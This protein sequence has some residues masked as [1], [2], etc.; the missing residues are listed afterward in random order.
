MTT[1]DELAARVKALESEVQDLK[2]RSRGGPKSDRPMTE[3][4]AYRVKFGD[5]KDAGHK[6]AAKELDL[7]YG[8]VFSCRGGY[9][10]K[11]VRDG[12]KPVTQ[13]DPNASSQP[14]NQLNGLTKSAS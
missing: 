3:M 4:D 11:G 6:A 2:S 8:Q 1:L 5:L 13:D 9:T 12:W 14:E 7:S 10:F